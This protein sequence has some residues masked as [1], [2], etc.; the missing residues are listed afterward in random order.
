MLQAV[1]VLQLPALELD[2]WLRSQV[3]GN[4]AL[5]L[6]EPGLQAG[7]PPSRARAAAGGRERSEAH[8]EMLRNLPERD[9]GLARRLAEELALVSDDEP[10]LAWLR[11]LVECLD[12]R[13][14]LQPDDET[15]LRLGRE[16][17]LVADPAL[18]E[19]AIRRL[20]AL[21]PRGLGARGPVEALLLQLDPDDA[22]SGRLRTLLEDFLEEL[23]R[24]KLPAVARTLGV[25]MP[26][27]Q[28]L[29]GRLAQ[30]DPAPGAELAD[31]AAPPL[32]PEL[33]VEPDGDGFELR[34]ERSQLAAVRLDERVAGLARDR[35]QPADVRR[36]LRGKLDRARWLIDALAQREHTVLRVARAAFE[37]QRAF[38]EHGPG[39][40]VPLRMSDL[41]QELGL[42]VSTVSRAV[43]GKHAQTPW[44]VVALRS[45]FQ[46]AAGDDQETARDDLL[47]AVRELVEGEDPGTPLSDDDLAA[48]LA[49]RGWRVAR[50]TVA[51]YRG[52]LGI[53]SSYRRRR[54]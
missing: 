12:E 11:F 18:L 50:R 46:G 42:H 4:E 43:A 5:E 25:S 30:L 32:R 3:E 19:R 13:G 7:P 6:I 48:A 51:K 29:L 22:D 16:Q 10:V 37:R 9:G 28:R 31:R 45:L 49:R 27:L 33:T 15:L 47:Q 20:Q 36:Y 2:A 38:L 1:E 21:E 52:E 35:G 40:L 8:D 39:H 17:G 44:G 14:F 34:L 54:Y 26:E 24:N 23:A 41:A 53:P